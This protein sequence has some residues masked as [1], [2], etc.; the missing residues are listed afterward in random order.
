[1]KM[2]HAVVAVLCMGIMLPALTGCYTV[3]VT[4]RTAFVALPA[5]E[6]FAL[7]VQ[8]YD[9]AKQATPVLNDPATVQRVQRVARK[10]IAA[11]D[12][13]DWDWEVT[14]FDDPATPNAW[15]LP[16]GKIGVYTGLLPYTATDG[17]LATVIAHEIAHAVARHG[18]QRMSEQMVL[19]AGAA[20]ISKSVSSE[21][22]ETAKVA[23]GL[24]SQMFV[25]LPY[26]RKDEYEADHIGL[27]YMARAGYDPE[28]AVTF[29][30]NF[31]KA[32]GAKPP[33]FLSTHPADANRVARIRELLPEAKAV[34]AKS[35]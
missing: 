6:E 3:P 18:G 17:Q 10:I 35:K 19:A 15:C 32:G 28:E 23:Y 12:Y 33:E 14:V 34:Y 22:L 25:T 5:S 31:S 30:E 20:A 26:S 4:G 8:A 16:G 27:V 24:G 13:P 7:G 2:R 29:W 9:E 11:S 21:Y 1:M